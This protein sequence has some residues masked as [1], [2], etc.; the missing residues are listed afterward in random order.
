MKPPSKSHITPLHSVIDS[1]GFPTT[2]SCWS[3]ELCSVFNRNPAKLADSWCPE[4][5]AGTIF[6]LLPKFG[7][8]LSIICGFLIAVSP[9]RHILQC[10]VSVRS[11]PDHLLFIWHTSLVQVVQDCVGCHFLF[12]YRLTAPSLL[13]PLSPWKIRSAALSSQC[14]TYYTATAPLLLL[15]LLLLLPLCLSLRG[16]LLRIHSVLTSPVPVLAV[17]LPLLRCRLKTPAI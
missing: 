2:G 15:L 12:T 16:S 17:W 9:W 8:A 4:L 14:L 7:A 11:S 3:G 13:F 10:I 5:C 1:S 6:V